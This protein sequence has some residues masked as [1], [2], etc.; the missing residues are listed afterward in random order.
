MTPLRIGLRSC[1][2]LALPA[3]ALLSAGTAL[4]VA[5]YHVPPVTSAL[6]RVGE[7]KRSAGIGFPV[8][9]GML[10]S[11]LVPWLFRMALPALRPARPLAELLFGLLWWA[12]MIVI[13]DAFYR[14]LGHLLDGLGW[15]V[16]A[17]VCAKV[18][19]DMFVFTALFASP[20]N[21]L[22]HLWKDLG[23]DL[24]RLRA[25]LRPGWYSRLVLPNLVPNYMVWFPGVTLVYAM[26]ADLQLPMANL[27]GCFWALMCLQIAANS[28]SRLAPAETA[29]P[30]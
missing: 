10:L 14:L 19:L 22:A 7:L 9:S 21:A 13:V 30:A 26:P 23:F 5:Y 8:F 3:A 25:N 28:R 1:R 11:G 16:A 6:A 15:P 27:I 12:P 20:A 4:V 2:E 29:V 24:R 18:C 17:L